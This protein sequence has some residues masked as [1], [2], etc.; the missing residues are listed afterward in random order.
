MRIIYR[1]L[2]V[3]VFIALTN[4]LKAQRGVLAEK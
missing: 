3:T 1:L 4:E 2:M